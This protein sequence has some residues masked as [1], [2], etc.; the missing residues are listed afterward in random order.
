MARTIS[1]S[2]KNIYFAAI[3]N[4]RKSN[5][6]LQ[7]VIKYLVAEKYKLYETY[8]IMWPMEKCTE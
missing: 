8:W 7:A 2:Q 4:G 6:V 5:S 1:I 3:Q